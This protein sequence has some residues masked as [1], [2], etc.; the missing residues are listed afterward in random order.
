MLV[1]LIVVPACKV[2]GHDWPAEITH[3]AVDGNR[4]QAAAAAAGVVLPCVVRADLATAKATIRTMAVTGLVRDGLTAAEEAH[5]VAA[6]FDLKYSAAAISRATG[7]SKTH[8]AA[9]RTAATL[10]GQAAQATADYPLTIDQLAVIAAFQ[11]QPRAVAQLIAAAAEGR[12]EHVAAQLRAQ[13]IEDEAVATRCA[14]LAGQGITVVKVEPRRYDAGPARP[15][16]A[17]RAADAPPGTALTDADHAGCPGHAAYVSADYYQYDPDAD[18]ED[19]GDGDQPDEL[20]LTVMYLCTDR[21]VRALAPPRQPR[22]QPPPAHPRHRRRRPGPGRGEHRRRLAGPAGRGLQSRTPGVDQTQQRGRRRRNRQTR[23][24]A[25]VRHRESRHKAMA[26]WALSQVVNRNTTYSLWAGDYYQN[27]PTLAAI[28][29]ADP[30]PFTAA[31]TANQHGMIL[32]THVVCAHEESLPR[33]AHRQC[34]RSRAAYLQ[35]LQTLGYVLSAVEQQIIDNTQPPAEQTP[36][37]QEPAEQQ[38]QEVSAA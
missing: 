21:P 11:D 18:D 5:A 20:E 19:H 7:R 23:I 4:R 35:H 29:G 16:D 38:D 10:T 9:A 6:L 12:I 31:A 28:L 34:D 17:L 3:V 26:A 8:L 36:A 25:A 22:H 14:E 37:E 27:K 30:A 2:P 13:Q 24:S 33:D 32:W 1:P 15:L